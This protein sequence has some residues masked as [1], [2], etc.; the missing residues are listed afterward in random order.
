MYNIVQ[1]SVASRCSVWDLGVLKAH[2]S[3]RKCQGPQGYLKEEDATGCHSGELIEMATIMSLFSENSM[4][5]D[6]DRNEQI[7]LSIVIRHG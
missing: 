1:K 2:M 4:A 5:S 3:D 6:T 7:R